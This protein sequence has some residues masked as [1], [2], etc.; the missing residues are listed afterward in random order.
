MF[1]L[2]LGAVTACFAEHCQADGLY[3]VLSWSY[4]PAT[5]DR[6]SIQGEKR[7]HAHLVGR[8]QYE[9]QR[10]DAL[11]VPARA[12]PTRQRRRIVDEASV[13]GAMLAADCL[14]GVRLK[15]VEILEH[16]RPRRPPC[17]CN[18][19]CQAAGTPSP[20]PACWPT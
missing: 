9:L 20:A 10:V 2:A 16:C 14:A 7:F 4:D 12:Y 15:A 19:G 6:E 17:H 11:T 1:G 8:T 3:P 13:L 18:C 5:I